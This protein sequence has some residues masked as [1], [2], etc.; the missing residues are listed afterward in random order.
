GGWLLTKSLP[1]KRDQSHKIDDWLALLDCLDLPE[2]TTKHET[3][4]KLIITEKERAGADKVLRTAAGDKSP[5]IGYHPGGSHPGKRWP[6]GHFEALIDNLRDSLGGRHIVFLGPD[7]ARESGFGSG[8][9]VMRSGLRDFM[10]EVSCCDVL[11][12]NDSG[13]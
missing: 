2:P 9:A 13:P 4:P 5:T 10:A 6:R 8:V 1:R 3:R 11:V 12:C 7:E